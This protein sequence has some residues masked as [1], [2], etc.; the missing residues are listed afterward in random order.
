M[1]HRPISLQGEVLRIGRYIPKNY[2]LRDRLTPN[3]L[4]K[5]INGKKMN[6]AA[7]HEFDTIIRG[8]F[9]HFGQ[10]LVREWINDQQVLYQ[11]KE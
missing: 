7:R 2:V 8:Q 1:Q 9:Q 4:V 10:V 6:D 3:L 5:L 11:F